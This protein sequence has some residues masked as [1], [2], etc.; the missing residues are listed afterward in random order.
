LAVD[1]EKSNYRVMKKQYS[2]VVKAAILLLAF[3]GMLRFAAF[4]QETTKV[5]GTVIDKQSKQPIPFVNVFFKATGIAT[6]TDFEGRYSLEAKNAADTLVAQYMGYTT[7]KFPVVKGRFQYIDFELKPVSYQLSEV[8]IVPGL[9]PAEVLLKKVID[10]KGENNKDEYQAYEY[11]AYTKIQIDANNFTERL[12]DRGIMK[13]FR[14]VFENVDTSIINGKAYLPVFFT[15]TMSDVYYRKDPKALREVI[16]ASKISGMDNASMAQLLGNSYMK[17][18]LY[19]NYLEFFEKNFVS[20]IANFGLAYYKYYLTDSAFI[21]GSWCYKLNFKPRRSQELTFTGTLWIA[22]TSFAIKKADIRMVPDANINIINE[23]V[24]FQ[25][26]QRIDGIHYMPVTDNIIADVNITENSSWT[27]GFYIHCN[28]SF[29]NMLVNHLRDES[30]YNNPNDIVILD[31]ATKKD[32]DYWSAVRHDSLTVEQK[33]ILKLA[34]TIQTVRAFKVYKELFTIITTGYKVWDLVELGPWLSTYSFNKIEGSRIRIGGRTSNKFSTDL[35]INAHLAYGTRDH[36]FKYGADFWYRFHKKPDC[37]FGMGYKYDIEQLGE[38]QNAFRTDYLIG[39]IIRRNPQDKL[40]MV[41]EVKWF[42]EHEWFYGL[43]N[44]LI[45]TRR[46]IFPMGSTSFSYHDNGRVMT[47]PWITT[48]EIRLN[49]RFAYHEKMLMG[50]FERVSLGTK[51]PILEVGYCYGAK[52]LW[53]GDYPYH[54]L[55]LSVVQWFNVGTIGWSR[56]IVEAGKI[57]GKLPYSLLKL[58][59]ANET[60]SFDEYAANTMNYYEFVSDEYLSIF[61]T[62]HFDGLLFNKIPLLKKLRWREVIHGR[63]VM[64]RM[65]ATNRAYNLL[66]E[67]TYT[68]GKPYYE[69]GVGI[70]NIFTV[71]RLDGIWRLSYLDHKDVSKFTFMFSVKFNF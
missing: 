23:I 28:T 69:A 65:N 29:R 31:S 66:P 8:V 36:T 6:T 43:T 16:S 70:E 55:Q 53:G 2:V 33:N 50:E 45:I 9:N 21:D 60:F 48:S 47:K 30:Y 38:S 11:E 58:H 42:Y 25:E 20:P 14:F 52:G 18:N 27:F 17:V 7:Q 44:R 32:N 67:N 63:C 62:H 13:P 41:K 34:D 54:K 46:Q 35:M 68:L 15:E 26:F 59:E 39:S 56:Y 19:D 61:Y 10:H 40:S 64:G 49:T 3:L 24:I 37:G 22:D 71:L 12:K 1:H 51:Y 4:S 57:W 5:M